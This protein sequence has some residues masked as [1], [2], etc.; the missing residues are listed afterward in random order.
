[1]DGTRPVGRPAHPTDRVALRQPTP[2]QRGAATELDQRAIRLILFIL[3]FAIEGRTVMPAP[4][5]LIEQYKAY[6]ADVGNIGSRYTTAQSFYLSVVSA[7]IGVVAF[8]AKDVDALRRYAW[9]AALVLGFIALICFVWW[10]TLSF[11]QALFGAKFAVLKKMEVAG[12]LYPV[13]EEEWT[14]LKKKGE[15][16]LVR[17]EKW[18]PLIIGIAA[19]AGVLLLLLVSVHLA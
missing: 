7:L 15:P 9:V 3:P 4:D 5:T 10:R 12:G 17:D 14:E 16:K 19:V 8:F 6:L 11:Y 2:R 13:F 1:M 18:I